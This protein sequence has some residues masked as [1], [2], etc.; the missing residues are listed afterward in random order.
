M[1][2][3]DRIDK[4]RESCNY[5]GIVKTSRATLFKILHYQC[6]AD[7]H[8]FKNLMTIFTNPRTLVR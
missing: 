4:L 8:S 2:L 6:L 7:Y 3:K 1:G 5:H